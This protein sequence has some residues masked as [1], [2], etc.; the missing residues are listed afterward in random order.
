MFILLEFR[1]DIPYNIEKLKYIIMLYNA[2]Q[3][4]LKSSKL[5]IYTKHESAM[6]N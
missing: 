4:I 5:N 2:M 6:Y 1:V 3:E